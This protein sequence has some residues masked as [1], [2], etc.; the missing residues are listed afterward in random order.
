MTTAT[1]SR[2]AADEYEAYY[3]PYVSRV[4]ETDLLEAMAKQSETTAALLASISERDAARAYAPGK[5]TI[6]QVVGH[7]GDAERVFSYR[8][9][10]FARTDTTPLPGFEEKLYA[11]AAAS[12]ARTLA[13]LAAELLA[14]RRSTLALFRG[15][16]AAA[17]TRRGTANDKPVSVRALAYI[18]LGHERHHLGVLRDRYGAGGKA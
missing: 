9:L 16:E 3:E 4:T 11:D 10:R 2:P 15:F 7:M 6:K 18:I 5:W 1:L 17:W 14:I 8:A 13:D 12:D